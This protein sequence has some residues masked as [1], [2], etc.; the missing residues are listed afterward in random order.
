MEAHF[1]GWL[2][3]EGFVEGAAGGA[4]VERDVA[5]AFVG[6]PIEHGLQKLFCEA[7]AASIGFGVHVEDPG[8]FCKRFARVA[9]PGCDYDSATSDDA[10][11]SSFREPGFVRTET[12]GFGEIFLRR[13]IDAVEHDGIA[14]SHLFEHGA[15]VMDEVVQI[16]EGCFANVEL[17]GLR[18]C[19]GMDGRGRDNMVYRYWPLERR[20]IAC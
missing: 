9:G 13:L 12:Q 2:E 16:V 6:A 17:H 20:R 5:E 15:A 4:G 7:A 10:S 11:F 8:A 18:C 1:V 19:R 14:V 3:A